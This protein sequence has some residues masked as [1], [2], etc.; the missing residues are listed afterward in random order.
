[1]KIAFGDL[2]ACDYTMDTP[3]Q[4]PLGGSQSA[5][6]YLAEQLATQGHEV[7]LLNN[8]TTPGLYRGVTCLPVPLT[9]LDE[10]LRRELDAFVVLNL[11]GH[12]AR[13]RSLIGQL[14]S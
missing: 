11:A 13:L 14:P 1:M 8:T 2:I 5:L 9:N 4:Q 12:G 6:C 3:Y 10:T 7:L